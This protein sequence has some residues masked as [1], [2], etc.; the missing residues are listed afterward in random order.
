VWIDSKR[1]DVSELKKHLPQE[2]AHFSKADLELLHYR[3]LHHKYDVNLMT[4]DYFNST[5]KENERTRIAY[6]YKN[7]DGYRAYIYY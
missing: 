3:N 4:V 5:N 2:F 1:V 6:Q 7:P